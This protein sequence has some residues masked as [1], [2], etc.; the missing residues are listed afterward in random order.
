MTTVHATLTKSRHHNW[1]LIALAGPTL[2]WLALSPRMMAADAGNSAYRSAI[3]AKVLTAEKSQSVVIKGVDPWLFFTPELRALTVG[4]FWGANAAAVSRSTN[5]QFADPLAAIIDFNEQLK[6]EG[7][8]LLLVPVPAKAAIYPEMLIA[9]VKSESPA[10]RIDTSHV[11]FYKVLKQQG[12]NV[13]DLH[14]EFEKQK[15]LAGE[16]LYCRTDSHWSGWG[17][18]VAAK[19]IAGQIKNRPWYSKQPAQEKRATGSIE[20]EPLQLQITGDLAVL[21]NEQHPAIETLQVKR[22][23]VKAGSELRPIPTDADSPVLLL[24]DSHTLVF[25][26]PLLFAESSG[27]VDHLAHHLELPLDLIGVRGS[28][29]NAA[30]I[31]WRRRPD[32]LKGKK[33]VIWCFSF[34]EFTENTDGWKKIA[35]KKPQ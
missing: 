26:D 9:G 17:V 35:V 29:A 11:E 3:Q 12:V 14:A 8:E 4:P 27:L 31:S 20:T 23:R 6:R 10:V 5:L 33:L 13:L 2:I 18:Q 16:P 28:G 24:G 19:A 7:I 15:S 22:V 25:H 1:Y 34:R 30:R 32:P 21:E